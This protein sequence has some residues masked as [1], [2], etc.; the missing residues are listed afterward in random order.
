MKRYLMTVGFLCLLMNEVI[1]QMPESYV[2]LKLSSSVFSDTFM[3]VFKENGNGKLDDRDAQKIANGYV[4]I[5]SFYPKGLMLAIEEQPYP[6][7][8]VEFPLYVNGYNSNQYRLNISAPDL[9]VS[10]ISVTLYD[11]Y[12]QKKINFPSKNSVNY[13]FSIDTAVAASHGEGRFSLLLKKISTQEPGKFKVDEQ[14]LAFP[15]PWQFK[16]FLDVKS[17]ATAFAE[18]RIKDL[19]GRT[20]WQKEFKNV[21]RNEVLSLDVED[22]S[23]GIYL[24][25]W[26]DRMNTLKPRTLKIIKL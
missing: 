5:A 24:L 8:D 20:V 15:N 13:D 10:G 18:V 21:Q 12:L 23:P 9:N 2:R 19:R 14:I 17:N 16:L 22:F 7:Q 6:R 26:I 11:K 3:L 4:N 25:E 1:A